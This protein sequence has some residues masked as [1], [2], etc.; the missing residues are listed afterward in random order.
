[1]GRLFW[2]I[3][4]TF[5]LTLLVAGVIA[6]SSVWF[7]Q[8]SLNSIK[9]DLVIRPS[10]VL[11][12][13]AAAN[14]FMFA[15]TDALRNFLLEQLQEAPDNLKVYAVNTLNK[16]LLN[17][18]VSRE[19]LEQ[20]RN[21][22]QQQISP[23]VIRSVQAH[24][25]TYWL[26][27]PKSGQMLQHSHE[28]QLPPPPPPFSGMILIITGII[29]SFISSILLA[30]YFSRPI[31]SL[32][33]AFR[34]F[35]NG[36]HTKRV[37]PSIGNR[38][39]DIADLGKD[40]DHMAAKL[41]NLMSSQRRLLHDVSHELRSPLARMQ[42]SI[43]LIRQQPEVLST[44]LDR[45]EH[46]VDRLDKLVGEILTLSRLESGVPQPKDEY[47][48]ILELLDTVI[49]DA[50]FEARAMSRDVVFQNNLVDDN[51]IIKGHGEL[52]YRAFENVIRNAIHHTPS[53][54]KVTVTASLYTDEL[55]TSSFHFEVDDEGPGVP[56]KELSNIFDPFQ[57][58][59]EGIQAHGGYGLGLAIA[60]RAIESHHG[61]IKATNR[62]TQGLQILIT[63]PADNTLPLQL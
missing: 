43:G 41:Q 35:A 19:L 45:I 18:A 37:S 32:R 17:R 42:A 27:V 31:H 12:V 40:F 25:E 36:D 53:G 28:N 4:L 54:T 1:M 9:N 5:W 57:K 30:W 59:H 48:D 50:R 20:V 8:R 58:Y 56:E 62:T 6:G 24:G 13:K 11:A 55:L 39:D 2:K 14:T 52:L 29:V 44:R 16:E 15:G 26:F 7:H 63:I 46:E 34:D 60:R 22:T 61:T 21:S 23:P 10:S 33:T 3:L 49:D 47:L 51:L 38:R